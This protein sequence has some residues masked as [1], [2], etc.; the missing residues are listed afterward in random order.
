MSAREGCGWYTGLWNIYLGFS[1]VNKH[2]WIQWDWL[3]SAL[4]AEVIL[5]SHMRAIEA[6]T[7]SHVQSHSESLLAS[8]KEGLRR[9]GRKA[10]TAHPDTHMGAE[11]QPC[12]PPL[13][14][15]ALDVKGESLPL[16]ISSILLS[17][18]LWHYYIYCVYIQICGHTNSYMHLHLYRKPQFTFKVPNQDRSFQ[19]CTL[20][21]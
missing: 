2:V 11:L 16:Q 12:K 7:A 17:M 9:G 20:Y 3:V 15:S 19:K 1:P 10:H 14:H 6:G 18:V 5:S 8:V 4:V 21:T 13:L